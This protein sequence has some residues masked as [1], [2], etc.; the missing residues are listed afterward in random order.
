MDHRVLSVSVRDRAARA[1]QAA[2]GAGVRRSAGPCEAG[3]PPAPPALESG[4]TAW[5]SGRPAQRR[6][7]A[8]DSVGASRMAGGGGGGARRMVGGPT[9]S[10]VVPPGVAEGATPRGKEVPITRAGGHYREGGIPYRGAGPDID[11]PWG[12]PSR[13]RYPPSRQNSV[14]FGQP[15]ANS[16]RGARL[17]AALS[18]NRRR[19]S[20]GPC[21]GQHAGEMRRISLARGTEGRS[22]PGHGYGAPDR[23]WRRLPAICPG[24]P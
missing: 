18:M 11:V 12:T 14:G 16:T 23:A 9:R 24:S 15:E 20:P 2:R 7:G 22:S 8:G 1:P 13:S 10:P 19:A 4:G 5:R 6:R 21:V 17:R 3:G